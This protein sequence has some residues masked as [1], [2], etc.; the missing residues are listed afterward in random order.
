MGNTSS[1][2]NDGVKAQAGGE[3]AP[4]ILG[5]L[6]LNGGGVL[7]NLWKEAVVT[8]NYK[9]VDRYIKDELPIWMYNNGQG[10]HVLNIL[11]YT[12]LIKLKVY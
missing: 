12:L 11:I 3:G 4:A 9:D 8:K 1:D 7:M 6:N 5:I 2:V 10:E